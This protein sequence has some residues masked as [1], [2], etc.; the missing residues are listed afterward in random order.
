MA[1]CQ[2]GNK[3]LLRSKRTNLG[4][5]FEYFSKIISHQDTFEIK[6][7]LSTIDPGDQQG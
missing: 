1:K 2:L 6:K 7:D 4:F 3:K 5:L